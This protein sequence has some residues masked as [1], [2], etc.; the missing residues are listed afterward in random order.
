[1][2]E[3]GPHSS[4]LVANSIYKLV[5]VVI[6]VQIITSEMREQ[7]SSLNTVGNT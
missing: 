6:K 7:Y 2:Q 3:V 5:G 4:P 1:M